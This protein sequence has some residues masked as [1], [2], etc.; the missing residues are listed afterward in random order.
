M[1]QYFT[2]MIS[3]PKY[4]P[5]QTTRPNRPAYARHISQYLSKHAFTYQSIPEYIYDD[6]NIL[7]TDII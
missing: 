6:N 2:L 3:D 7:Q 4:T 5:N 1:K